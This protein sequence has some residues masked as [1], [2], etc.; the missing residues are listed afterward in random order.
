MG[1]TI[2]KDCSAAQAI[3]ARGIFIT[4]PLQAIIS[5]MMA[6]NNSA[7]TDYSNLDMAPG[8]CRSKKRTSSL[9]AKHK[10]FQDMGVSLNQGYL[11]S[12]SP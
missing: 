2:F 12:G 3:Q 8:K 7:L 6:K 10:T 5:P 11:F 1:N 4:G 9:T